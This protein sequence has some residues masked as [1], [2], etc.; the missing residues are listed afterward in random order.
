MAGLSTSAFW[1]FPECKRYPGLTDGL[2]G[3]PANKNRGKCPL[4]V[5]WPL[6]G[7]SAGSLKLKTHTC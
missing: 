5:V 2:A 4:Q 3:F 7:K 6:P 1:F